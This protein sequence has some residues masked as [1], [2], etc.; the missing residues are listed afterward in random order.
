MPPITWSE[1]LFIVFAF[2][3]VFDQRYQRLMSSA[4]E[5]QTAIQFVNLSLWA[6]R[7]MVIGCTARI[8]SV[9]IPHPAVLGEDD[10]RPLGL[11]IAS[12]CYASYGVIISYAVTIVLT[13]QTMI[14][15]CVS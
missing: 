12:A 10:E 5:A 8:V 11:H 3:H 4:Q 7:F 6:N 15:R 13:I 9:L 2:G 14:F 1:A